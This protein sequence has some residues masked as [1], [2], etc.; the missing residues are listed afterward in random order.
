MGKGSSRIHAGSSTSG[1]LP[2]KKGCVLR[3]LGT[4]M[5]TREPWLFPS[6][7]R[8]FQMDSLSVGYFFRLSRRAWMVVLRPTLV[9]IRQEERRSRRASRISDDDSCEVDY[10]YHTH[11]FW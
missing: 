5:E 8:H 11:G 3:S 2:M 10:S 4:R 7:F 1:S 9:V 6:C